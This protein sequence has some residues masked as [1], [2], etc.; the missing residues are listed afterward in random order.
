MSGGIFDKEDI[1]NKLK[2]LE[3]LASK[4]NFWKDQN[5][6]KK[7]TKKKKF[8]EDLLNSYNF[9]LKELANIKDL[10]ELAYEEKDEDLIGDCNRKISKIFSEIKKMK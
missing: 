9:Q 3:Q 6:V 1:Q 7:T 10:Y 4:K 2:E 5:L 8:F